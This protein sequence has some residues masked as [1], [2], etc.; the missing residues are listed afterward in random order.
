MSLTENYPTSSSNSRTIHKKRRSI[1]VFRPQVE[2]ITTRDNDKQLFTYTTV[3]KKTRIIKHKPSDEIISHVLC[4]DGHF[5]CVF[6]FTTMSSL[7]QRFRLISTDANDNVSG[8][9]LKTARKFIVCAIIFF[10][11][12]K[13]CIV[14]YYFNSGNNFKNE[15]KTVY[16]RVKS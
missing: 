11:F 14:A 2:N 1:L 12:Q 9:K 8:G 3:F 6:F 16:Y 7:P 15:I 4:F 5:L 10:F 13:C